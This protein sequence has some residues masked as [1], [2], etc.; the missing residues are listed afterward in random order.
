MNTIRSSFLMTGLFSLFIN[1]LMLVSPLYMLQLYDRVLS[2]G[3]RDTLLM[4]SAIALFLL[5]LL[6]AL[7]VVRS[8]LLNRTGSSLSDDLQEPLFATLF[9]PEHTKQHTQ[10]LRDLDTVRQFVSSPAL[11]A[12]FDA[13]WTPLFLLLIF[14][15]HPLLGWIA[16]AGSILIFL[17]ALLAELISRKPLQQAAQHSGRAYAFAESSLRNREVLQAMGMQ[18]GIRDHWLRYFA[19]MV[20][21]QAD[22]GERVGTLLGVTKSLRFIPQGVILGMGAWLVLDEEV[23]PGVMIAASIV[24]GRALAPVEQAI[25]G[26]RGFLSA[27]SAWKRIHNLLPEDLEVVTAVE[28]PR[29]EGELQVKGVIAAPAGGS[30]PLLQGV[31]FLLKPGEG[32]AIIGAS[33]SGKTTLA[34]LLMGVWGPLRGEIRLDG[35][36]ISTWNAEQMGRYLG[37]LPQDVELFEGTVS[38]NIARF[39]ELDSDAVLQAAVRAGCHELILRLPQGYETPIGEGGATLS[40]GQR[41]RVGLARALYGNPSLVLLD[42]PDSNLDKEGTDALIG[43]LEQLKQDRVTTLLITHN[44]V[45]IREMGRVLFIEQGTTR[46]AEVTGE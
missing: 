28:L 37:Y 27:R 21:F 36:N 45:L 34:R 32:V 15:M 46:M 9:K 1:L 40:G 18:Q 16:T 29:P 23:T 19:P 10:P 35:V 8:R 3:S 2:S 33:G 31:E 4:L 11:T 44:P 22:A 43:V 39:G 38:Q 6:G 14:W 41:Q 42:E 26:W 20:Q 24:M 13:P 30:D 12:F 7:E 25:G 5:L 17:L